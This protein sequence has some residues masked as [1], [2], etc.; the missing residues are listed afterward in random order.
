[1]KWNIFKQ[2]SGLRRSA[3]VLFFA[4]LVTSMGSFIWPMLTLIMTV[5]L[6]YSEVETAK[7]FLLIALIF[8]PSTILGGKLA[9][10]FNKKKIIIIFDLISVTFFVLC[11]LVEPGTLMLI[12]FCTAG[13]FAT[14]EGPA[15]EALTIETSLPKDRD[16]LFSLTYLGGNIGFIIG[17]GLGGFMITNYLSLAFI[18]D[19]ITT[20]ASTLLI[21]LFVF[22]IKQKEVKEEDKNNYEDATHHDSGIKILKD[23]KS[24][25]YQILIVAVT[26]FIYDQWTFTIPI[27]MANIFGDVNGPLFYGFLASFNGVIVII[28]TPILTYV[29]RK[30]FEI[31]KIISAIIMYGLAFLLLINASQL[32]I[33]FV[34]I[35]LFTIGEVLN[36]ISFSPFLSRRVPSTHRGRI[37]S[38][39]GILSFTGAILGKLLIGAIIENYGFNPAYLT[40][41]VF[42]GVA[43]LLTSA[44][45][46]LDKKLFPKL[47][48]KNNTKMELDA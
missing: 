25:L 45:Y 35:F 6:G 23:R 39:V 21:I 37:K 19:G 1:M 44:N 22:P 43:A 41:I 5:K 27:H 15:H 24:I 13:L 26:A 47:Y 30:T 16:R 11:S 8:L 20:L 9:D 46:I 7:I 10:K 28:G 2:Y 40:M 12:F 17:A 31:P 4:R 48:K 14:M 32:P 18:I 38:Y 36:S 29:L 42:T 33:F 3:Y 34:F